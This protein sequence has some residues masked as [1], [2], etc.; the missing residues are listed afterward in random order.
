MWHSARG[1]VSAS[2]SCR[3][4]CRSRPSRCLYMCGAGGGRWVPHLH[5]K[6]AWGHFTLTLPSGQKYFS[7]VSCH[8][9]LPS[10]RQGGYPLERVGP[11]SSVR[12]AARAAPLTGARGIGHHEGRGMER[13][14]TYIT[15]SVGVSIS[16]AQVEYS[17]SAQNT[18]VALH[19][20]VFQ[21]IIIYL[22]PR[23]S[24]S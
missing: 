21:G 2:F 4:P 11:T 17:T 8:K 19:Q 10:V 7:V 13:A 24:G 18:V 22:I 6:M 3:A 20:G 16:Y 9:I 14:K 15:S 23:E 1:G 5:Q 12:L